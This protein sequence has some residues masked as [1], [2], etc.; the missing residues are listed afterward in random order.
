MKAFRSFFSS[1]LGS[2]ILWSIKELALPSPPSSASFT[3]ECVLLIS[4]KIK[5]Y[6]PFIF[7]EHMLIIIVYSPIALV[8][9]LNKVFIVI[10]G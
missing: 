8:I 6:V 5:I 3:D 9:S 10:M 4:D 2:L 1:F 7:T